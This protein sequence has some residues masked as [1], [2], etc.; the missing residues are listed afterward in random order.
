MAWRRKYDGPP[1]AIAPDNALQRTIEEDP[2]YEPYACGVPTPSLSP[3]CASACGR[4][5]RRQSSP[6]CGRGARYR[7]Y[8]LVMCMCHGAECMHMHMLMLDEPCMCHAPCAHHA[9]NYARTQV[10]VVTHGNTLRALVMKIDGVTEEDVYYT[11]VPTATPLLYSFDE[12]LNHLKRHGEW[13]DRPTAPR[14]GRYCVRR[15]HTERRPNG[16]RTRVECTAGRAGRCHTS[17][18]RR[19]PPAAHTQQC[20]ARRQ[21]VH[22]KEH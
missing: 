12:Q 10:M 8:M 11:D 14:H 18:R 6:R 21:C 13:G 22:G 1:P 7:T 4:C 16:A 9:E 3:T 19:W 17:S 5:G 20:L 2:R 15:R